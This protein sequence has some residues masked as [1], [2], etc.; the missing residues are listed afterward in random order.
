M[1]VH[2]AATFGYD[3]GALGSFDISFLPPGQDFFRAA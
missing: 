3:V 2:A 1:A